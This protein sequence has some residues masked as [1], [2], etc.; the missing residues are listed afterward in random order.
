V[1]KHRNY[2]AKVH[3]QSVSFTEASIN[4]YF[5]LPNIDNDELAT[6]EKAPDY[7]DI[8]QVLCASGT[9]WIWHKDEQ[10]CLKTKTMSAST[11]GWSYFLNARLMLVS[12]HSDITPD[13][14][15]LLYATI[16]G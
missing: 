9:E 16:K 6:F 3:G 2:I 1:A 11:K 10:K 14:A 15:I 13:R 8:L 12:H 4:S 7:N 5:K